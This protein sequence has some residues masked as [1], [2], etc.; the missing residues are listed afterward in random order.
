LLNV[1]SPP[2][3]ASVVVPDSVPVPVLLLASES[4]TESVALVW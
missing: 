1:A 3:A 4:A 2:T